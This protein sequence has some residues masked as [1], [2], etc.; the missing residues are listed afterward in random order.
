MVAKL[1]VNLAAIAIGLSLSDRAYT[2]LPEVP[3]EVPESGGRA[4]R[5][6]GRLRSICPHEA[7]GM[8]ETDPGRTA[9]GWRMG[10]IC[11]FS[12]RIIRYGGNLARVEAAAPET[13]S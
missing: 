3:A 11:R 12:T 4:A 9:R 2:Q 8:F 10:A 5:C 1:L 13:G 6:R 7:G